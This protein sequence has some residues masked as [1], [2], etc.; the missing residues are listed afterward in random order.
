MRAAGEENAAYSLSG[1][2]TGPEEHQLQ[3]HLALSNRAHESL[4]PLGPACRECSVCSVHRFTPMRPDANNADA[5]RLE[6]VEV[7]RAWRS[8]TE[9]VEQA[10]ARQEHGAAIDEKLFTVDR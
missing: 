2:L 7:L 1:K 4:E 5:G 6:S 9:R 10:D 8:P 3:Q